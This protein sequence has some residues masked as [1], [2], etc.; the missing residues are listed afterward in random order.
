MEFI[1]EFK[2]F[3]FK[4]G[5]IVLIHYWYNNMVTPVKILEKKGNLFKVSHDIHNSKIKNAPE[6]KIKSTEIISKYRSKDVS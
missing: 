2:G 6:E 4:E 1:L 3:Q 5:D